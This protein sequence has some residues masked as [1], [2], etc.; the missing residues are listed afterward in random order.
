MTSTDPDSLLT[1][2]AVEL[3][4][5]PTGWALRAAGAIIDAVVYLGLY[6]AIVFTL[7]LSS[8]GTEDAVLA[9]LAIVALVLCLVIAPIAVETATRGRSLGRLAVGARIV[10]DDGGAIGL[11]HAAI[12]ALVGVFEIFMTFGAIAAI[13]GLV[14]ERT[15]RVGDLVAGTYSQYE[16]VPHA[17]PPV[18]GIPPELAGWATVADVARLPDGLARR[19]AQFLGQARQLMPDR[20]AYIAA[21][22]AAEVSVY[23]SP[24]PPV[25]PEILLAGVA[26]VRRE[27]EFTALRLE[28]QRLARLDP[29]LRGTPH[30][31]PTRG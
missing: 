5:R 3:D 28:Q 22:L 30:D 1:G 16:R 19:V 23:V 7:F 15:R 18:F 29:A 4:L 6:F 2:E 17:P 13:T 12:R 31:F 25:A 24:L 21:Q 14:T 11:R 8:A 20:R 10:R 27:R 9:I 26:V